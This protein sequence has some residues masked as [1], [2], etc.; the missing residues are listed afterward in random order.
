MPPQVIQLNFVRVRHENP[1]PLWTIEIVLNK[2]NRVAPLPKETPQPGG[3]LVTLGLFNRPEPA[4]DTEVY[5]AHLPYDLDPADWLDLWVERRPFTVLARKHV[6]AISGVVGDLVVMWESDGNS[7]MGRLFALKSGPRMVVVW[8]RTAAASYAS[9]A[10]EMFV[11]MSNLKFADE[12]PGTLAEPIRWIGAEWP[13]RWRTAI[14]V[15]WEI[16]EGPANEQAATFQAGLMLPLEEGGHVMASKLTHAIVAAKYSR[17]VQEIFEQFRRPITDEGGVI[18]N[19]VPV[20]EDVP[21]GCLAAWRGQTDAVING[22]VADIHCRVRQYRDVWVASLMMMP[23]RKRA[24]E[25]WM[26]SKRLMDIA[27]ETTELPL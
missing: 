12:S 3:P 17:S 11:T 24:S 19:I 8:F 1:D 26:R 20:A 18:G 9:L 15:S 27:I 2:A 16:K 5:G 21:Q 13:R 10:E 25:V 4:C 23:P 22:T 6:P 7:W 14:P